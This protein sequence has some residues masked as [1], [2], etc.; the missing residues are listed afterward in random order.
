MAPIVHGF[1]PPERFV[2]GTVG[3]PGARTFFGLRL[4]L[5]V[6]IPPSYP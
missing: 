2:T 1:D 4:E 6:R 5:T 3:E